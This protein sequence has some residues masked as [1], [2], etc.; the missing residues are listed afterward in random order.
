MELIPVPLGR[1]LSQLIPQPQDRIGAG[2]RLG[3]HVWVRRPPSVR[4][5]YDSVRASLDRAESCPDWD[6]DRDPV[7][8]G[9]SHQP[10]I[11]GC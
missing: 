10:P 1:E 9:P 3:A 4:Q 11:C 6:R 2:A 7:R 5:P 8:N